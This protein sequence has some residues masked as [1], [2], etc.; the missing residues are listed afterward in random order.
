M[1]AIRFRALIFTPFS[2]HRRRYAAGVA[3]V[4]L[5]PGRRVG[6]AYVVSNSEQEIPKFC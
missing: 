2:S 3:R 1:R 5:L 4:P 6:G